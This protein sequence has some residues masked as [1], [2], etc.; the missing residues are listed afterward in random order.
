[1]Y[2]SKVLK[3]RKDLDDALS[4][5][6]RPTGIVGE[7][8]TGKTAIL[9][10]QLTHWAGSGCNVVFFTP[11][12][13]MDFDA[14]NLSVG[15]NKVENGPRV[16]MFDVFRLEAKNRDIPVSVI[17]AVHSVKQN[18]KPTFVLLDMVSI[19]LNAERLD[20]LMRTIQEEGAKVIYSDS[21]YDKPG[22]SSPMKYARYGI[23]NI[24]RVIR[25][26]YADSRERPIIMQCYTANGEGGATIVKGKSPEVNTEEL[27]EGL[28]MHWGIFHRLLPIK[29][30]DADALCEEKKDGAIQGP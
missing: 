19:Y 30:E 16:L 2:K 21:V 17:A 12:W 26:P 14:I 20:S 10:D 5:G 7:A 25:E 23:D 18:N 24:I 8:A 1:M 4:E 6:I 13:T 22:G 27:I 28:A 3:K 29:T 15:E 11:E 9:L